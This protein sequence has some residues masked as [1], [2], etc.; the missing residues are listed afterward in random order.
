MRIASLQAIRG[1]G[2]KAGIVLNPGTPVEAVAPLL[3]MVDLVLL[4]TVNPGFGGQAFIESVCSKVAAV[5][6]MIG[7]RPIE[8][9]VDGGA[10]RRRP[11]AAGR[12]GA[13]ANVSGGGVRR[14]QGRAGKPMPETSPPSAMPTRRQAS[15]QASR[16]GADA[17]RWPKSQPRDGPPT[18]EGSWQRSFMATLGS[19]FSGGRLLRALCGRS[20]L[21]AHPA[22]GRVR[23]WTAARRDR[24]VRGDG[25]RGG[26]G[27]CRAS[28]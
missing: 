16:H 1:L 5:K 4:M 9:E 7:D 6:A 14:L 10:G 15:R 13:G 18:P 25:R 23:Q 17:S 20:E 24:P 8:I 28:H 21:S 12:C 11:R 26:A 3:D 22:N 2:K 27:S 19:P